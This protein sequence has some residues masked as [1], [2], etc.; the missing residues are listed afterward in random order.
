MAKKKTS[1]WVIVLA[2]AAVLFFWVKGAY[3]NMVTLDEEV[4]TAMY[5][6]NRLQGCTV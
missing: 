3:N 6:I 4:Q 1:T 2:V 5:K